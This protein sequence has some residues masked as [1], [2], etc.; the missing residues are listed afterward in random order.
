[1]KNL[2]LKSRFQLSSLIFALGIG[3]CFAYPGQPARDIK[4]LY[5]KAGNDLFIEKLAWDPNE[6]TA[7]LLDKFSNE[8]RAKIVY[9]GKF[10]PNPHSPSG[11][12]F[13]FS[14]PPTNA[15]NHQED[16]NRIGMIEVEMN[17][18]Y[19]SNQQIPSPFTPDELI[20]DY[21]VAMA[22]HRILEGRRVLVEV[23]N[24][25]MKCSLLDVW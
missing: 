14:Y 9:F 17:I 8:I 3:C 16:R 11:L 7:I 1:M 23:S 24:R 10:R 25:K 19:D 5:C 4:P 6:T 21:N 15:A 2:F 20:W 13:S 12:V 18:S 22:A